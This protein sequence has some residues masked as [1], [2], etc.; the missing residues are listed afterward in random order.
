M[1]QV[2]DTAGRFASD[3]KSVASDA[4]NTAQRVA[5]DAREHAESIA[6]DAKAEILRLRERVEQLMSERVTPA[7]TKVVDQAEYLT[8]S[9]TD[10][11]KHRAEKVS[12]RVQERP[13]MAIGLAALAGFVLAAMVKR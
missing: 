6:G 11:V 5:S 1:N 7:V 2:T 12:D 13:L 4:K 8:R 3:A 10:E 9:A